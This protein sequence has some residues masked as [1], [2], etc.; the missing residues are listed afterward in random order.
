MSYHITNAGIDV[1]NDRPL[2]FDACCF[3]AH[4]EC[5]FSYEALAVAH[6]KSLEFER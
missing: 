6:A 4:N 5:K 2:V 3:F 1:D